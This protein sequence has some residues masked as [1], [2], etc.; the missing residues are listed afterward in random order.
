MNE[1]ERPWNEKL[2]ETLRQTGDNIRQEAQKLVGELSDP[3]NHEKVKQSLSDMGD[4]AKKT[5]EDAASM[6]D[7]AAKKAEAA[8]S[9]AV[10]RAKKTRKPAKAARKAA[11]K[12]KKRKS[13]R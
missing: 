12:T 9:S 4:W 6:V 13:K 10:A 1:T 7:Q 8:I 11:K 5:A 2:M 3:A